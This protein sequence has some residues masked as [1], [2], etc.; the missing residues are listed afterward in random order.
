MN[1]FDTTFVFVKKLNAFSYLIGL[2][3]LAIIIRA[4]GV[5]SL[6][7]SIEE[8]E[9]LYYSHPS[10][11]LVEL[12]KVCKNGLPIFDFAL[13]RLWFTLVGFSI[14]KA[15]CL[16]FFFNILLIPLGYFLSKKISEK[17]SEAR[18]NAFLITIALSLIALANNSRFYNE[19]LL[20]ST[21]SFY[22]FLDFLKQKPSISSIILFVV[23][24]TASILSH[25]FAVF[26]F[27][28][29][30]LIIVFFFIKN[31]LTKIQLLLAFISFLSVTII[32]GLVFSSF[33]YL[34]KN[35]NDYL[36]ESSNPL[37]IFSHVYI[38]LGQDPVLFLC[39][40]IMIIIY[41]KKTIS[42]KIKTESNYKKTAVLMWLLFTFIIPT[43]VDLFYKPIIR[44]DYH[45]IL[46][47]PLLLLISWGFGLLQNRWKTCVIILILC[48]SIVNICFIQ[49]Y[50]NEPENTLYRT[51]FSFGSLTYEI[52]KK[53]VPTHT[54]IFAEQEIS[55][56]FYFKYIWNSNYRATEYIDKINLLIDEKVFV[57]KHREELVKDDDTTN[58]K[59][60]NN[61]TLQDSIKIKLESFYVYSRNKK[62]TTSKKGSLK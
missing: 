41:I 28:S 51:P 46:L 26:L 10:N 24:T 22:F 7:L 4:I 9:F 21:L 53:P 17:E 32:V 18:F 11:P 37:I 56:N 39:C 45:L 59:I 16:S 23:F 19:L 30:F 48:S 20:F 29:Q 54:F 12:V 31:R 58:Q 42:L 49:N 34:L 13:Y 3:I 61:Y 38:F 52:S 40:I 2:C 25:Y 57:I 15:K 44:R 35:G 62:D 50:Y 5:D 27:V 6:N 60:A 43:L 8:V 55:Y 33:M 36:H 1:F 14:L 47:I